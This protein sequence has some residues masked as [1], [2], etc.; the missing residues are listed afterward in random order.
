[1]LM[2][3]RTF[4]QITALAGGGMFVGMA[5]RP[6]ALGQGWADPPN[7]ANAF[8]AI[9]PDG[10]VTLKA[11]NPEIGQGVKTTLP[12]LIAEELE[13]DWKSVRVEQADLDSRYGGQNTGGSTG[14]PANWIPMRQVGAATRQVLM[15]AAARSWGVPEEECYASSGRIHHRPSDRALSYAEL[16]SAA[17]ALPMPELSQVKLKDPKDYKIVGQSIMGVDVPDIVRGKPVFGSDFYLPGMLYAVYEKC[18]VLGGKVVQAN[19]E[20]IKKLPGIRDAFV[21]EGADIRG[22]VLPGEPGLEPGVAIVAES[23]WTAQAARKKL[24]ITWNEGSFA[25]QSTTEITKRATEL[26]QQVPARTLKADGDADNAL[27]EAAKQVEGAYSYPFIAHAALEPRNTT[28]R[29]QDGK[30][31]IWT[32]SQTPA[33]GRKLV[34]KTLGIAESAITIH[35]QRAGGGFG[36]G[37]YNDYMAE[38][39]WIARKVVAPIKLLWSRADDMAHDYYRPGGFHF[40]KGGLDSSGKIVAWR[41]HFVT[42]GDGDRFAPDCMLNPNQYP[43]GLI[44]N[45]GFHTSVMPLGLRTGA[46]RAPGA[47]T[48]AFVIE[49][50]L[51]ELAH[52]AG[53]DPVQFRLDLLSQQSRLDKPNIDQGRLRRV[54]EQVAEN[55]GWG[56]RTLAQGRG[57]GVAAHFSFHG[58]FAEVVELSVSPQK[59]VQLHKIWVCGDVGSQIVNP[60]GALAQV[61][62]GVIDGLGEIMGQEITL[63]KGRVVQTS[64]LQHPMARMRNVP[65]IDTQFIKSEHPPTGLGEP[66]LPPIL[67]AVCNAI[68]A[69]TGERIRSLP[70]SKSGFSWA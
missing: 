47:N 3:R 26:S 37:L 36:R 12:M 19:V 31:E 43:L 59:A 32:T 28:A 9:H 67:P 15:I 61:E 57:L 70:L 51:D 22:P 62:G 52:T 33:A 18:P 39:A 68:F 21:V 41:D 38:V 35:L 16:A 29:Y 46:L 53:K 17:A 55:S 11:K 27:R 10:T 63:E 8:I 25:A 4:L 5:F 40:L 30:L 45:F 34:S 66:A 7:D 69:A 44:P 6:Y 23:W 13:V 1:M 14:V 50:F 65:P 54:L 48:Y 24:K 2:N 56:K 49:S 58:Y 60:S 42:F 64:Y 20:A